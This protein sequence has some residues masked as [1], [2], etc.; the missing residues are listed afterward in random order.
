M[1]KAFEKF[2]KEFLKM[3]GNFEQNFYLAALLYPQD[4]NRNIDM[5]LDKKY[6]NI[7]QALRN[8]HMEEVSRI[9]DTLYKYSHDKLDF[10]VSIPQLSFLF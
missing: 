9:H 8:R 6:N 7:T 1:Y 3:D 4:L 2:N 10:F 5:F